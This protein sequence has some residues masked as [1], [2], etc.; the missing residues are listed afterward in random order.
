MAELKNQS[1]QNDSS[2]SNFTQESFGEESLEFKYSK[3]TFYFLILFCATFGNSMV[4]YVICTS[5]RMKSSSH[6]LIL[7][8]AI[9]DLF[10]PLVSIPFDFALEENDYVW[11]YG[12]VM[13]KILSPAATFSSTASSLTL[14]AISLDRYRL[15]M[16]PFKKKLSSNQIKG[17]IIGVY[18]FSALAVSPYTYGLKL[19]NN[20]C[21]EQWS[22]KHY[23]QIYTLALFLFQYAIPLIFMTIM[24]T[25]AIINLHSTSGKVKHC[26]IMNSSR[27]CD[28]SGEPTAPKRLTKIKMSLKRKLSTADEN[29]NVRAMKMFMAVVTVFAIFMFPNQVL[30]IWADFGDG[31][32]QTYFSQIA[33]ICWLFTYTN[34]VVNPIIFAIFSKDFRVGFKGVFRLIFC[35]NSKSL[36]ERCLSCEGQTKTDSSTNEML[37]EKKTMYDI[38]TCHSYTHE[39]DTSSILTKNSSHD[40]VSV[41]DKTANLKENLSLESK[42]FNKPA[43]IKKVELPPSYSDLTEHINSTHVLTKDLL[44]LENLKENGLLSELEVVQCNDEPLDNQSIGSKMDDSVIPVLHPNVVAILEYLPETDC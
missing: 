27:P 23:R 44:D 29:P 22:G 1:D 30:W 25:L 42:F 17:I 6:L 24:Y 37:N 33:I 43:P 16:H 40:N 26:S 13:C 12:Y 20:L 19:E 9:C 31:A 11:M 3:V 35:W 8:L 15:L 36:P 10:T 32:S 18:I 14:A 28:T 4:I 41:F 21:Q 34:S 7:N 5:K 2:L 38:S 39:K